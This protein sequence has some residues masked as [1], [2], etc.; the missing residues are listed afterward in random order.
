MLRKSSSV[1]ILAGDVFDGP[2]ATKCGL[3]YGKLVGLDTEVFSA[4]L[5]NSQHQ[6]LATKAILTAQST[7]P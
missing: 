5:L 4:L 7:A 1:N 2:E 3:T 6:L